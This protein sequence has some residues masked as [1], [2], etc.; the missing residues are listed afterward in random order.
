MF[1]FEATTSCAVLAAISLEQTIIS[2]NFPFPLTKRSAF[3]I[4]TFAPNPTSF[5]AVTRPSVHL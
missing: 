1:T 2:S 3:S 4:S 5:A